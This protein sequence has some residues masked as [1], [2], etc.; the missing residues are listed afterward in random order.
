MSKRYTI[1]VDF[2]G[3]LHSYISPWKNAQTIPDPP[4]E[5]AMEWL[6]GISNK[7]DIAITSTRNKTW[8]GRRAMRSWI[9]ENL[10]E[11]VYKWA[12]KSNFLAH[13]FTGLD[14]EDEVHL[15]VEDIMRKITF[16]KYKPP[17]L[18]Y[19]D[20]RAI[21]FEGPRSFPT[22]EMI[23]KARPWNKVSK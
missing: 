17:A 14:C 13:N 3:V 16:P 5:G 15:M 4:V 20:D 21:R 10:C 9:K 2:D 23:R 8:L 1:A 12:A 19:L 18:I 6:R 11:V 22:S 7:Y